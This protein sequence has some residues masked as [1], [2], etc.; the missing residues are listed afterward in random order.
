M[1][2]KQKAVLLILII[3]GLTILVF[4]YL[5]GQRNNSVTTETQNQENILPEVKKEAAPQ[6][7]EYTTIFTTGNVV[8][9][10][11]NE[12]EISSQGSSHKRPLAEG[13]LIFSKEQ[14]RDNEVVIKKDLKDLVKGVNVSIEIDM[15][16]EVIMSVQII[17]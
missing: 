14:I 16:K 1:T 12:L 4:W 3:I 17:K 10:E 9:L 13:A 15:Q 2:Q 8:S 11:G 6:G 5:S 7:R